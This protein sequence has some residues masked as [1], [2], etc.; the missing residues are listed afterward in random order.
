M[1]FDSDSAG[2][3]D[4][5]KPFLEHLEDLRQ[6]LIHCIISLVV[7]LCIAMPFAKKLFDFLLVPYNKAT[8]GLGEAYKLITLE[9]IEAFTAT[10]KIGLWGALIISFPALLFFIGKFIF[11]GLKAIE[12]KVIYRSSG[13][14]CFLFFTGVTLGYMITLPVALELMIKWNEYM[15][16]VPQWTI[17]KYLKFC[18]Q[19]IL[20]FGLIFQMPVIIMVLGRLGLVNTQQLRKRRR[21]TIVG[22]LIVAMLL[23]PPDPVTQLIM[24]I[25]LM[26]LY[27]IC[28]WMLAAV[29]RKRKEDDPYAS[30]D[31]DE[32]NSSDDDEEKL[33][34]DED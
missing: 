14:V 24:A 18:T 1:I 9:P 11:P 2:E 22:L 19:I 5:A 27:E 34:K 26:G 17:Q 7:G 33:K 3:N 28:I 4:V 21:H 8:D 16:V 13:F 6:M 12:K 25:P 31:E 15:D 32:A 29:E 30:I 20:A 23:T 10:L